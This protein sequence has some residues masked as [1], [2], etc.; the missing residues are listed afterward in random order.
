MVSVDGDPAADVRPGETV[1]VEVSLGAAVAMGTGLGFTV[2]EG[3]RTVGVGQVT[4]VL[5]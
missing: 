4:A 3:N 1:D 5:G 2:R